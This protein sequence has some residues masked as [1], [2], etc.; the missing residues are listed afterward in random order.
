MKILIVSDYFQAQIGYAKPQVA[1]ALQATGHTVEVL[2]SDRY[3]PFHNYNT[4][5]KKTIGPRVRAVGTKK[6]NGITV[7]RKKTLF[8]FFTRAYFEDLELEI[9]RRKPELLIVVGMSSPSM[10]RV[11]RLKEN[12]TFKLVAVDSHLPSE[13]NH[14]NTVLKDIFYWVF[15]TFF[16]R[17][18]TK[19]L[20]L[21]IALQDD[22]AKV[23]KET[24]GIKT[25]VTIV[26][27]GT[28]IDQFQFT[29]TG[30]AQV[31]KKY[32][33]PI[34]AVVILY[35]GKI[36]KEKG[37]LLLAKTFKEIKTQQ[38]NAYLLLVGDGPKEYLDQIKNVL[39]EHKS[40]YTITGFQPHESMQN[41]YS[42]ADIAVWPLQESL[43]MVDAAACSIPF[44]AND[45]LG[46]KTRISNNNAL[47]Y[48]KNDRD[49]LADKIS[50][51]VIDKKLRVAM[52]KRGRK[53][54]EDTLSWNA[55]CLRF[56]P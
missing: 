40:S 29:K 37:V 22:T 48:K 43:A 1:K 51:L 9:Q 34:D 25:P 3:F 53:L 5:V 26:P 18:I 45:T 8:E 32:N 50:T 11:A 10:V 28:N 52:G 41:F 38:K 56:I 19:S 15:R 20:D 21:C 23:I 17:I 46:D 47:L 55:L 49:D 33:I 2:T 54:V 30:A 31:K 27:N 42:A 24:Y 12:N 4:S 44:I 13:L 35:S 14:G 7:T 36:I 39:Q 6:E 16:S